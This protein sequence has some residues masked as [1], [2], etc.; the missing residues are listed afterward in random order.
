MEGINH[1]VT[2]ASL[3]LPDNA[4]GAESVHDTAAG[5]EREGWPA[6]CGRAVGEEVS[7]GCD[8]SPQSSLPSRRAPD[9]QHCAVTCVLASHYKVSFMRDLQVEYI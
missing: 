4:C 5:H 8:W 2:G 7:G 6:A 3:Y 1:K 9:T